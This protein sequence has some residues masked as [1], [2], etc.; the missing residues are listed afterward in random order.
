[1]DGMETFN[2]AITAIPR[3]IKALM[4]ETGITGD[5]FDYLI[6]HQAN[7]MMIDFIVRKLKVSKDKVPFCL[8]KYGNTSCASVPLTIVSELEGKMAGEKKLL[9]SAIGAG[10]SFGTAFLTVKDLQVSP[11][12][13]F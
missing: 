7:K 2:H 8:Q 11:V 12:I 13:E 5:D 9:L 4:K 1:M 10:W 3:Q 6:S